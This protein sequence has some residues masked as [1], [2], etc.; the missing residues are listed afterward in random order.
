MGVLE[1]LGEFQDDNLDQLR[2]IQRIGTIN[3]SSDCADMPP[4]WVQ[5]AH[6]NSLRFMTKSWHKSK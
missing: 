2:A 3:G 6:F 5:H 1:F 4:V